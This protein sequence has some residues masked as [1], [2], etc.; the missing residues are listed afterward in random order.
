M[1]FD[2]NNFDNPNPNISENPTEDT[3]QNQ[4]SVEFFGK[5]ANSQESVEKPDDIEKGLNS[6]EDSL[7]SLVAS[8]I[9]DSNMQME[10]KKSNLI[11]KIKETVKKMV[12]RFQLAISQ[13]KQFEYALKTMQVNLESGY[14]NKS[15]IL[16]QVEDIKETLEETRVSI[17]NDEE[18]LEPGEITDLLSRMVDLDTDV[19]VLGNKIKNLFSYEERFRKLLADLKE[20]EK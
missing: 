17:N 11:E 12:T 13:K 1:N 19:V 7:M 16:K 18:Q 9:G 3:N 2:K 15:Q 14:K 4:D 5:V 8:L 10:T 6:L 20:Q